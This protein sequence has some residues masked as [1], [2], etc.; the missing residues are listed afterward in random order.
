MPTPA[1]YFIGHEKAC[2]GALPPLRIH[3]V[4]RAQLSLH[5]E[6]KTRRRRRKKT[7]VQIHLYRAR[8]DLHRLCTV[9]HLITPPPQATF[10]LLSSYLSDFCDITSPS[11]SPPSPE[12]IHPE[13]QTGSSPFSFSLCVASCLHLQPLPRHV[14]EFS[15]FV[16]VSCSKSNT[17][18]GLYLSCA[19]SRFTLIE[20]L[21][22]LAVYSAL[23]CALT[24][25][26]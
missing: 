22:E 4:L 23:A 12:L 25:W 24:V 20:L 21:F 2:E 17:N 26:E 15:S 8:R 6:L 7:A 10:I 3:L 18:Q 16:Y 5:A 14:G 13:Q 9:T 19:P 1:Q 11:S